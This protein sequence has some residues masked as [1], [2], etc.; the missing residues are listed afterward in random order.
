MVGR[1]GLLPSDYPLER[2]GFI[3]LQIDGLGYY[4]LQ[5]A[6]SRRFT[7]FLWRLVHRRGWRLSRVRVG[8]PATTPA[9]QLA[10]FYGINDE[11]P[12]FRWFDRATGTLQISKTSQVCADVEAAA[13]HR[14]PHG[15]ILRHGSG[16]CNMFAAEADHT[17]LTLATLGDAPR[18]ALR[19]RDLLLLF[20]FQLGVLL[21][22]LILSAWEMTRELV[23][24]LQAMQ[25]GR[26]TR[27]EGLFP[28]VRIATNV[29]FREIATQGCLLDIYRA[30]PFVYVNFTGYDEVAHHRGPNSAFAKWVLR[31]IDAQIKRIVQTAERWGRRPYD[32]VLLSD[33]G[34]STTVPFE[35][36]HGQTLADFVVENA[37]AAR[38]VPLGADHRAKQ[39]G[40]ALT[41]ASWLGELQWSLPPGLQKSAAR[42][43]RWFAARLPDEAA[44]LD[45]TTEE[46]IVVAP[47]GSLAHVYF[48][49]SL[50]P[51]TLW[52]VRQLQPRLV[53]GAGRAIRR[54]PSSPV[55]APD[56]GTG[57]LV[58]RWIAVARRG[59]R[60][61]HRSG[62]HPL[63]A[64][65]WRGA[66]CRPTW[67]GLAHIRATPA[68]SCCSRPNPAAG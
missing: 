41:F 57:D 61:K 36:L 49:H 60:T 35:Q 40:R 37:V 63:D 33:H 14:S 53:D 7:P 50:T 66:R 54:L 20:L 68:T 4:V 39:V 9:S 44:D 51:L 28:L 19:Y 17:A 6:L 45:W 55:A 23:E 48:S 34:Q 3:A 58:A 18:H 47:T 65:S 24:Q 26:R 13:R 29:A 30:V 62:E 11:V 64:R 8:L 32:V 16:Y 5:S 59:W 27:E 42:L 46:G 52:E 21:R 2:R 22:V 67:R 25:D 38:L 43:S 1:L 31:D 56:G 10:M 15:G 12:G